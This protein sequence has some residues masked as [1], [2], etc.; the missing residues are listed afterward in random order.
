MG[1]LHGGILYDL[2]DGAM[3]MAIASSL[4]AGESFT[5][6]ELKTNFLRPVWN[7]ELVARGRVVSRGKTTA[8]LAC[9][10][11]DEKGRLV[12]HTTSTVMILTGDSPRG[13]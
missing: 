8:L 5:T 7:G 4:A 6:L 11:L 9:D 1:T 3:G 12:A 2:A 13:L 10:I